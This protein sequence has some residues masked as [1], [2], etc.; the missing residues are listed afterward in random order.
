MT[1]RLETH[2]CTE[3]DPCTEDTWCP[4]AQ[5]IISERFERLVSERFERLEARNREQPKMTCVHQFPESRCLCGASLKAEHRRLDS[6]V[7]AAVGY[8]VIG[9]RASAERV[10]R[11]VSLPFPNDKDDDITAGGNP[12]RFTPEDENEMGSVQEGPRGAPS[13][14]RKA[15]ERIRKPARSK[16]R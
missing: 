12:I 6:A 9:D 16:A 1:D 11:E 14:P 5:G 8:L 4:E 13:L 15:R 3:G 2:E 10:L 7:R